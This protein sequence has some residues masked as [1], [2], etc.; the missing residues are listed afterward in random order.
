MPVPRHHHSGVFTVD[1]SPTTSKVAVAGG[2]SAI[3]IIDIH[4]ID[5]DDDN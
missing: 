5:R 2:D 1:W 4:S 3:R